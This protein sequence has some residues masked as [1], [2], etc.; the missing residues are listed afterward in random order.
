MMNFFKKHWIVILIITLLFIS[1]I[2]GFFEGL[3]ETKQEQK[4]YQIIMKSWI[5]NKNQINLQ[6]LNAK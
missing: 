3:Y 4:K 2:I 1:A 6:E 5:M